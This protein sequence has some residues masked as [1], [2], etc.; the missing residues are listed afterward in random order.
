MFSA[1][2]RSSPNPIRR[3]EEGARSSARARAD[4]VPRPA[5]TYVAT[6]GAGPLHFHIPLS[7]DPGFP[8]VG[9]R[10]CFRR[11]PRSSSNTDQARQRKVLDPPRA[12]ERI[13][14][15]DSRVRVSLSGG[16]GEHLYEIF[17]VS[18]GDT[19]PKFAKSKCRIGPTL[20]YTGA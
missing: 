9:G 20:L 4:I 11:Y 2:P 13:L 10:V 19:S 16:R 18:V 8:R 5:R 12:H 14:F 17:S 1:L 15:R 6:E 3:G 7:L